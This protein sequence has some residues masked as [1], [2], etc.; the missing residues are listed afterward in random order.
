MGIALILM[1]RLA[2]T[3]STPSPATTAGLEGAIPGT[4]TSKLAPADWL[5]AMIE[6]EDCLAVTPFEVEASRLRLLPVCAGFP[7]GFVSSHVC[8]V[9]LR[10]AG[11]VEAFTSISSRPSSAANSGVSDAAP[12]ESENTT[13]SEFDATAAP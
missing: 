8:S 9:K 5:V 12:C 13:T 2:A 10:D 11:P 7:A 6:A 1:G 4:A 3:A